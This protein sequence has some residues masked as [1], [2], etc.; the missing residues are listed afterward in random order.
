MV[1]CAW[2]VLW[3]RV[4]FLDCGLG[5]NL[6]SRHEGLGYFRSGDHQVGEKSTGGGGVQILEVE[7]ALLTSES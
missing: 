2:R 5:L 4:S 6:A 3:S 7:R 1:T